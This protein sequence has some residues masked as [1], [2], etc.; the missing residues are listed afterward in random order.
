MVSDTL[1]NTYSSDKNID[2]YDGNSLD[3]NLYVTL[4]YYILQRTHLG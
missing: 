3:T 4:A 1:V 2:S